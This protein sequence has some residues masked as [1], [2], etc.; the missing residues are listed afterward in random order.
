[1]A[2]LKFDLKL[3]MSIRE[4]MK[5]KCR[6]EVY[7][8]SARVVSLQSRKICTSFISVFLE[9]GRKGKVKQEIERGKKVFLSKQ[10]VGKAFSRVEFRVI[11]EKICYLICLQYFLSV[12][13]QIEVLT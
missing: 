8:F 13:Y 4:R 12:V 7:S 6:F 2:I 9:L 1:M 10:F 5:K 3:L 11:N